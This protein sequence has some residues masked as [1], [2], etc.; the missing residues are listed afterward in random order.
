MK[1]G[2]I[3]RSTAVRTSSM[4]L[5]LTP[6]QR[7]ELD[8]LYHQH[9]SIARKIQT[10]TY[11]FSGRCLDH[12]LSGV[13]VDGTSATPLEK[14]AY[15]IFKSAN[16][17]KEL[18]NPF[19]SA[20]YKSEVEIL[21]DLPKKQQILSDLQSVDTTKLSAE[22]KKKHNWEIKKAQ[23]NIEYSK[24]M[25]I[26]AQFRKS[27]ILP[28]PLTA[29]EQDHL[30]N[31]Y[32]YDV[33]KG[34]KGRFDSWV[35]C[36]TATQENYTG[37]CD[38]FNEVTETLRKNH[39]KAT[40][41]AL[42][43]LLKEIKELGERFTDVSYLNYK[44]LSFFE[45]CWRPHALANNQGLLKGHWLAKS[46]KSQDLEKVP[47]SFHPLVNEALLNR[48][49]L[50]ES[51]NCI[52]LD[53]SFH[54]YVDL[55][56]RVNRLRQQASLTLIDENS[57][58]PLGYS[59]DGNSAKLVK[60]ENNKPNRQ[61]VVTI[62]L[63][64]GEERTYVANYARNPG[65]KK[66][67]YHDLEVSTPRSQTVLEK[68]AKQEK[69][70]LTEDEEI[71]ASLD[72][73]YIFRYSRQGKIPVFATVK[74]FYFRKENNEYYLVLPTI[75]YVDRHTNNGGFS[76]KELFEI[77]SLFQTSWKELRRPGRNEQTCKIDKEI[78]DI[79][80]DRTL[81]YAGM[82]INYKNPYAI[83]YYQ[84]TNKNDNLN[85]KKI[86]YDVVVLNPTDEYQNLQWLMR[87]LMT[88]I[89]TTRMFLQN[90]E[91]ELKPDCIGDGRNLSN[92]FKLNQL[93]PTDQRKTH[94][95]YIK[96]V[97]DFK[98]RKLLVKDIKGLRVNDQS[99]IREWLLS[100]MMYV[101]V[102]KMKEIRSNIKNDGKCVNKDWLS[103]SGLIELIDVYYQLQKTFND[104]GDGLKTLPKDHV[105]Q[106]GEKKRLT[107]R[108]E[109]FCDGILTWRDNVKDYFIK[110]LFSLA[111]HRCRE[112]GVGIIALEDLEIKGSVRYRKEDN[113]MYNIWPRGQMKK[114][115]E[116]AFGYM[117]I[118]IQFVDGNGTS[119]HE[120]ETGIRGWRDGDDLWINGKDTPI[121][122]D[123]NASD[124][125]ALRGLSH[126]T[127]IYRRVLVDIGGGYYVNSY[128]FSK[129]TKDSTSGSLRLRGAESRLYGYSGTVY[130]A[131]GDGLSV[132]PDLTST[133]VIN[134]RDIKVTNENCQT[135]Y[136]MD[137]T[138]KWYPWPVVKRF[139]EKMKE[140]HSN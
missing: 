90:D 109:G 8:M 63:P 45:N 131:D 74:T 4:K 120:A 79:I 7:D 75:I 3:K 125:I 9:Q 1:N 129:A 70:K 83:T 67:Y 94:D 68:L 140:L 126:H 47:Y 139:E 104:S 107:V 124:M 89:R 11:K 61:L 21:S 15:E 114:C 102:R 119:K 41:L 123:I 43:D 92:F 5:Q 73:C 6:H 64:S 81:I 91:V 127:N 85:F 69:R 86:N 132:V 54:D 32:R 52:L 27:G 117:N 134:G 51:D 35:E 71:E 103:L 56:D 88:Y 78:C 24:S 30:R 108:E 65:E 20:D 22:E 33:M 40:I 36:D 76:S 57:P 84:V 93:L 25:L 113:R 105:Y 10:M 58:I 12:K 100:N 66:C 121:H 49:L 26:L 19:L 39:G 23:T 38:R 136:K 62:E 98:R 80:G 87:T 97:N 95:E 122:S 72:G 50:W 82:D 110:K 111:A 18:T 112:M 28:F 44:F 14:Q 137:K 42:N 118:L 55:F 59:S 130:S 46:R 133:E 29:E 31:Y 17:S 16:R 77:R 13:V 128:E 99:P 48:R 115:A 135:Y 60:I 34:V 101:L 106:P 2:K 138:N 37:T 116:D 53:K 96:Q